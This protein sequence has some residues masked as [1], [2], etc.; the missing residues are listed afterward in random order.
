MFSPLATTKV[1]E[2]RSRSDGSR[3]SRVRLPSPPTTSPTNRTLMGLILPGYALLGSLAHGENART[4]RGA[5]ARGGEGRGSRRRLDGIR[6]TPG[7]RRRLQDA[8]GS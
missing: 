5:R 7:D 1:G 2:Y 6:A 8:N 4:H 3:P